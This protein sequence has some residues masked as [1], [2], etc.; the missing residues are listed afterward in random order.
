MLLKVAW[1]WSVQGTKKSYFNQCCQCRIYRTCFRKNYLIAGLVPLQKVGTFILV[2]I[3]QIGN[4][5]K[6]FGRFCFL[7]IFNKGTSSFGDLSINT[8]EQFPLI[9]LVLSFTNSFIFTSFSSRLSPEMWE[10]SEIMV[11]SVLKSMG[12]RT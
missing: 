3:L 8:F 7:I 9:S 12:V 6:E 11:T 5:H 2:T 10:T 4:I 1:V